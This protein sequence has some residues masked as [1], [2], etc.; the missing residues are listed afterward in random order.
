MWRV[1]MESSFGETIYEL[2]ADSQRTPRDSQ[3]TP[4]RLPTN[5]QWTLVDSQ[6][7][8]RF[9]CGEFIFWRDHLWTSS[10]L[11]ADSQQ[12][13]TKLPTNFQQTS[14]R[15]PKTSTSSLF[16]TSFGDLIWRPHLESSFGETIGLT[17]DSQ[18][19]HSGLSTNFQQAPNRLLYLETS[20]GDLIWRAHL[21]SSF[22]ETIGLSV[23]SQ[24]SVESKQAIG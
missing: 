7:T 8:P 1:H 3:W 20:F 13:P 6:W 23:D 11:P 2:P 10:R 24:H 21:K 17:V 5:F 15:L 12:T 18:Q 14:I 16:K 19:T 9:Q 22:G 4:S